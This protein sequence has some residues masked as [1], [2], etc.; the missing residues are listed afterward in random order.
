MDQNIPSKMSQIYQNMI[1]Y[2]YLSRLRRNHG[3]EHATL[4]V[5]AR[6]H[7]G[8]SLAGHSDLSGFWIMG[9]VPTESMKMAVQEA[10]L[11]LRSGD[12]LLAVHPNCGTNLAVAG[13][14]AT[15]AGLLGMA[16]SGKR[17]R[18]K[19]ERLPMAISLS[20]LAIVFARP[21]GSLLQAYVTTSGDPLDLDVVDIQ[22]T[23][24]G[25]MRAHRVVTRG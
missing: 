2:P 3:L 19:L 13:F 15:L 5:L 7:P 1:Q 25:W 8:M 11:R 14:M 24:R 18:D 4:H 17:L 9:D 16:G 20:T 21:L 12:R 10:L 6:M 22:P 23:R